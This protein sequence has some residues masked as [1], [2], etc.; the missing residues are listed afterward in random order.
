MAASPVSLDMIAFPGA[1]NLPIFVAQ[2]KGLFEKEGVKVNLTTT[3][4]S[5][6]QAENLA[7]GK[8]HIAGIVRASVQDGELALDNVEETDEALEAPSV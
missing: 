1:P 2:E 7:S 3:P 6:Y 8:F 4:N 5:A